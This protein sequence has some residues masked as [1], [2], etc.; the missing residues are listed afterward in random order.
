MVAGRRRAIITG[1]RNLNVKSTGF[2]KIL[3]VPGYVRF[4]H[5]SGNLLFSS[6]GE[7]Q[8]AGEYSGSAPRATV[9]I[10]Q[11]E[12]S[13]AGIHGISQLPAVLFL[14]RSFCDHDTGAGTVLF[15]EDE[16]ISG[17]VKSGN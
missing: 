16:D 5:G 8:A 12:K 4:F 9:P 7:D 3:A 1:F 15:H 6:F 10:L 17:I 2:R 13:H 14:E 11:E